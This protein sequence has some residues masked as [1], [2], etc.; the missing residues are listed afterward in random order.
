VRD[1]QKHH[2]QTLLVVSLVL[3]IGL[4]FGC[5]GRNS[6][7]GKYVSRD[8]LDR[9]ELKRN[10]TYHMEEYGHHYTGTYEVEGTTIR[11]NFEAWTATGK[12]EGNTILGPSEWKSGTIWVKE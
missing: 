7:A 11:V 4:L 10:G 2:W 8:G 12:I 9:L 5:S 1:L 3:F 6:I